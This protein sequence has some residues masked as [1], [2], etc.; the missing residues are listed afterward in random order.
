MNRKEELEGIMDRP[1]KG[2][3]CKEDRGCIEMCGVW[4]FLVLTGHW[5]TK[6]KL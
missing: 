4:W 5:D 6:W 2:E 1:R 3:L